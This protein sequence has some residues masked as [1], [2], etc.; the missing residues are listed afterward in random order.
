[1]V[2]YGPCISAVYVIYFPLQCLGSLCNCSVPEAIELV[3][4]LSRVEVCKFY[5]FTLRLFR[6][7]CGI[8]NMRWQV[9]TFIVNKHVVLKGITIHNYTWLGTQHYVLKFSNCDTTHVCSNQRRTSYS[10]YLHL[11]FFLH[12]SKDFFTLMTKLPKGR[13]FCY[14]QKHRSILENL[15]MTSQLHGLH[16]SLTTN[17]YTS[18]TTT[19]KSSA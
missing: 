19:S 10:S 13:D 1:M 7:K 2:C 5:L 11:H 3:E 14:R 16:L 15:W 6:L 4:T 18:L 17:N 8:K 9:S 12:R